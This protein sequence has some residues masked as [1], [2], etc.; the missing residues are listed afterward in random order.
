M[1]PWRRDGQ[2]AALPVPLARSAHPPHDSNLL[3]SVITL[4]YPRGR[5]IIPPGRAFGVALK[6]SGHFRS[7]PSLPA[8]A[9]GID[10]GLFQ[11]R[12]IALARLNPK[13]TAPLLIEVARFPPPG[14]DGFS[15]KS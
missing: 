12:V 2:L 11:S 6:S 15:K 3:D 10:G 4:I 7:P 13:R 9:A 14:V 8:H 5:A 1:A